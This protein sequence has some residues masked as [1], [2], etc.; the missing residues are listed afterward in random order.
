MDENVVHNYYSYFFW[1]RRQ[2]NFPPRLSSD[3]SHLEGILESYSFNFIRFLE[4]FQCKK[5]T[6]LQKEDL[7]RYE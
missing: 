3:Y 4:S 6:H 2:M 7:I 1:H 5:K